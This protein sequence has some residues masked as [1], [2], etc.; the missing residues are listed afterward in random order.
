MNR[1]PN[2]LRPVD[3]SRVTGLDRNAVPP[4][5]SDYVDIG[6][7]ISAVR[8][9]SWIAVVCS[10]VGTGA[11][12][13][14][15][16]QV[17]P[18]YTSYATILLDE[19]RAELLD[20]VSELPSAALRDGSV[21][22]EIEVVKSQQ[23]ALRVVDRLN[24]VE[25]PSALAVRPTPMAI[26]SSEVRGYL[27]AAFR[28]VFPKEQ[29]AA[30]AAVTQIV[31]GEVLDP[32]EALRLGLA[33]ALRS[34]L[35]AERVG[36]SYVF[37]LSFSA[38][39][40]VLAAE[41][42][43][44]YTES[45]V[46]FQLEAKKS[47]AETAIAWTKDRVDALRRSGSDAS[48]NLEEFRAQN[49]LVSVGGDRLLSQQQLSE[50]LTQ[51]VAAKS[52]A[53]RAKSVSDQID[54]VVAGGPSEAVTNLARI[55]Q[56]GDEVTSNLRTQYVDA[57]RQRRRI[58]EQYGE[59]HPEAKR[60]AQQITEIERSVFDEVNRRASKAKGD[61]DAELSRVVALQQGLKDALA[62]TALD[63]EAQ[64]RLRQ[65][66][67][68]EESYNQLYQSALTRLER[69][70]QQVSVPIVAARIISE[71]LVPQGPSGPDRL[72]Y[73]V[74]GFVLG[75][76]SG[77]GIGVMRELGRST[78]RTSDDI[79]RYVGARLIASIPR[80]SK[81]QAQRQRG[82]LPGVNPSDPQLSKQL[83]A[84][85]LAVDEATPGKSTR[86]VA[87]ISA[88][89]GEGRSLVALNF[90]SML[91]NHG[92]ATLV[93]VVDPHDTGRGWKPVV[94]T[95]HS[96]VA[97]LERDSAVRFD[98]LVVAGEPP[99]AVIPAGP[100]ED[101]YAGIV[102]AGTENMRELLEH[103]ADNAAY[104]V[105]DMAAASDGADAA[106]YSDYV[107]AALVIARPKR[108]RASEVRALFEQSDWSGRIVGLVLNR[109]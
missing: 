6:R 19:Q 29:A 55:A 76:V 83:R 109:G 84:I 50:L 4:S 97:L 44:A 104:V 108:S 3:L 59:E 38:P 58:V 70:T 15:V 40:P 71:P 64:Y 17:Q 99:L 60:V 34:N 88:R 37:G 36:R 39:D 32:E 27:S 20:L 65:L 73:L 54:A 26:A 103:L 14:Y 66:E 75:A 48:R 2:D 5:V 67:Q 46:A 94:A 92:L 101:P 81:R 10:I 43:Q 82:V 12:L 96:L 72:K 90:A 49:G 53:S 86:A 52:D 77:T 28:A 93:I 7:I 18:M 16:L 102:L 61:Y 80:L 68:T 21:Q 33:G 78:L 56:D 107:D 85:K 105:F 89:H 42:T 41:I 30:P 22:S 62:Q 9:Q 57:V 63:T 45:Y 24:L 23:L 100:A 74:L 8:R 95:Q 69:A 106:A 91:A 1:I 11:A 98:D 13:A 25:R 87:F 79:Q 35:K 47:A 51:L 31:P